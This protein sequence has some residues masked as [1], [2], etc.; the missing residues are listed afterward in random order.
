MRLI[1]AAL[2]ALL[3]SLPPLVPSPAG[4]QTIRV[5]SKNFTEQFIVA[6]LYAGALEAAG[7]RVERKINLGAT[8]VAHEALRTGAIDLYP[9]YTGTGILAVMK[10]TGK[11]DSDPKRV[12]EQ[13]KD[14]YEREFNLT[15][16]PPSRVNNG[17]AIVVR[18]ETA[19]EH[20]LKTLTDLG[21]VAGKLKLGAGSE[22][23][24]RYDGL[25]GLN[26]VYGITFS[27]TRQFAALRLRYEA[28]AQKQ[29]D[30]ANGFSTDWQIAAEKFT[31]LDD[32]KNLFP[33]YELAPVVRMEIA[34][35]AKLVETLARVNAL[36]DNRT[37]QE[38]NRQVEVDKR[39]PR[40]VAADFLK[41]A[42]LVN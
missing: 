6:E 42:G 36:I 3:A 18:P 12:F 34:R 2:A 11:Q 17:Y 5:G 28:L 13:V 39:E 22:F 15:W 10:A 8:L 37:M 7:Y 25:P 41:Q 21:R 27:V 33:P 30:V 23:F 1:I 9:E 31:A 32:D 16:L 38:L 4:A 29:V 20:G 40:R 35:D 14:F 19:R 26:E 24:D